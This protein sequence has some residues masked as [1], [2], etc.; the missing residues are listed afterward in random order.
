MTHYY[1]TK[2]CLQHYF[3]PIFTCLSKFKLLVLVPDLLL[4]EGV[5]V[6]LGASLPLAHLWRGQQT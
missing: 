1:N 3:L 5:G 6:Q 2:R 4:D